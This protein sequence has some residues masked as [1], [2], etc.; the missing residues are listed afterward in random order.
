MPSYIGYNKEII[1]LNYL[2]QFIDSTKFKYIIA[3]KIDEIIFKKF[4]NDL[5]ITDWDKGKIFC[6]ATELKWI[7]RGNKFHVVVITD[8]VL[9]EGFIP[10][11]ELKPINKIREV[12]L[13]GEKDKTINGWFEPRI[14][15][16]LKYPVDNFET[17][18]SRIKIKIKEYELTEEYDVF[19]ESATEKKQIISIIHRFVDLIGE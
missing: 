16:I 5:N 15:Q 4:N 6:N 14:P 18:S 8:N 10:Y 17:A 12:Y 3:E 2:K 9:P 13:W 11:P 19:K 1:N 7:K